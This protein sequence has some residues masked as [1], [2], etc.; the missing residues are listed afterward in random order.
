MSSPVR[1]RD[2]IAGVAATAAA[3]LTKNSSAVACS[4]GLEFSAEENLEAR[5]LTSDK[6]KVAWPMWDEQEA[7]ALLA[8]LNSGKWG[9]TSGGTQLKKFEAAF[10][11]SM[12][13]KYC[14]A[15]SS[16][17]TALM[18]TLGALGIGPGDEV[19]LPPYTFVA[20]FNAITNSY[21]LPV[22]VDSDLE[23][24]QIDAT[25]VSA[26]ITAQTKALMPVHIGGSA[27]DLD[28]LKAVALAHNVP[29]IEDACQAPL[30][31]WRGVPV[32]THGLAGCF[33]FQASK[34]LTSGEGGAVTT[35]DADFAQ[36]CLA[37]HTPGGARGVTSIGR[38]AN[39][40]LTEF[41]AGLLVTQ[42]ARLHQH[43]KLR[44][45][46]AAYLTSLLEKIP[47]IFPAKLIDGCTRSGW[48][49]YMF[50]YDASQFGG[51]SRAEFLKRLSL[52]GVPASPGY[53][54]LNRSAHV[55]ALATNPHYVRLY[56][57]ER[58]KHWADEN[59]CPVNDRLCEQA[60]WFTQTKLL[61]SRSDMEK[62][63][64]AIATIQKNV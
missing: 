17:T 24:F 35:N 42:L 56:G 12:Q 11:E 22:F 10:A 26:A 39:Y 57:A 53:T 60:V 49:L 63:A 25:K 61:G 31:A 34:N 21:A 23:S 33:S 8:V 58:M 64:E 9:R 59:A 16:G 52:A 15:T 50:R 38:G 5:G 36:R 28:K 32:G 30:A 4:P 14:L 62:T 27:A 37:F 13:A 47:G 1:R 29:M 44:D 2:L 46:N 54:S 40:R 48:H 51:L 55:Q 3:C 6:A 18:T 20:S 43:A 45:D 19:I 7:E 41:Q